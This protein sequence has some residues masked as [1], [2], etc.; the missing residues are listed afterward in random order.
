NVPQTDTSGAAKKGV[1]NKSLFK[2]DAHQDIYICPAGEELPHRLDD[3][4]EIPVLRKQTVEH[5][6]GTI[7]MW[8]G[9]TH[10]LMKRKKNVSIEMNLHV[11]AYNLKR[12]MT[13]MGTTGLMEAIRQ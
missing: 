2:Y 4:S 7:K 9:A 6:F 5:P 13:I 10:F 11:L 3:N 12:M 8:M 1:F